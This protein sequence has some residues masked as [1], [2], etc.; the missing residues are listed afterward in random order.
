MRSA[1]ILLLLISLSSPVSPKLRIVVTIPPLKS[2]AE[3]VVGERGE[4]E[5][6]LPP[7][8]S[9]HT[10]E[11]TAKAM[12]KLSEADLLV[13]IGAGLEP[14]AEEMVK[15]VGGGKLRVVEASKGIK[16]LGAKEGKRGTGNPHIWLDPLLAVK[17]AR[18]IAEALVEI[19]PQGE[20]IYR[21]NFEKLRRRLKELHE[22]IK[23]RLAPFR[24]KRVVTFHRA[25]D[26][27][28]RR[29]GIE[30]VGAIEEIPGRSPT[31]RQIARIIDAVRRYG[32]K[33]VFA[34][35]QFNPKAAEVI[36][37]EAGVKLLLLD[38]LGSPKEDYFKLMRRNLKALEE[39]FK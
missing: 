35:P 3:G 38:P 28:A 8:A 11:P 22:E 26:Y 6:L 15:G 16:L 34:E 4:V 25:W 27:F 33:L 10:Y 17:M 32:V 1:L 21:E 30:I 20:G 18:N 24:N 14:W 36:A 5:V 23:K 31:P 9:P 2:L 39:G 19:D 7:G 13:M 37:R 29:Y 12:R